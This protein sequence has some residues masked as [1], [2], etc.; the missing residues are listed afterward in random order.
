MGSNQRN[1]ECFFRDLT[2]ARSST[3]QHMGGIEISQRFRL[4]IHSP[5]KVWYWMAVIVWARQCS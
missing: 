3:R 4:K 2:P 1:L 5:F